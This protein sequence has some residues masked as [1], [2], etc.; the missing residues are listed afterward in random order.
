MSNIIRYFFSA[1]QICIIFHSIHRRSRS[2]RHLR[3]LPYLNTLPSPDSDSVAPHSTNSKNIFSSIHFDIFTLTSNHTHLKSK[4]V[5]SHMCSAL[6]VDTNYYPYV[7]T[8]TGSRAALN[9]TLLFQHFL[10]PTTSFEDKNNHWVYSAIRN[11]VS[12]KSNEY[13]TTDF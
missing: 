13:R 9:P 7:L 12:S 3:A 6:Q 5:I 2:R 11:C 10:F 4:F 1:L 8:T